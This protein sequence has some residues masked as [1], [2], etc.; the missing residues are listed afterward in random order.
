MKTKKKIFEHTYFEGYFK[1]AVGEFGLNDLH[2]ST[3][4][5][6]GWL[7]KIDSFL[8]VKEGKGRTVLEIGC[9]IGGFARLLADRGFRV[10]ATDISTYAVS[11]AKRLSPDI[12]FSTL[13]IRKPIR[14]TPMFDYI[15]SFEVVEHLENPELAIAHM[16]NKLKKS[17]YLIFSS[18]YPYSWIYRDPT[19]INVRYPDEWIFAM[20]NAGFRRISL[21]KFSLLPFFYRYNKHFHI[22]LPFHIPLS[23]INNVILFVGQK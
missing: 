7:K 18:P 17:G 3:N 13:D 16:Y 21:Y 15:F 9:S 5:F 6:W 10:Y 1:R 22:V 19:H 12:H 20:R 23:F 2:I 8:P 4:W 11:R 14:L